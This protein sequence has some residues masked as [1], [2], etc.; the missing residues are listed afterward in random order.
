MGQSDMGVKPRYQSNY[1][2]QDRQ[3]WVRKAIADK[4]KG[5]LQTL[6][7]TEEGRWFIARLLKNEGLHS[8]GFTG[9]SGTFYNEGRRSVAVDIYTNIKT[10]LGVDAI[11]QLHKAQEDLMEFEERALEMAKANEEEH[12]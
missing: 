1:D 7:E 3:R 8:S 12:G 11:R 4:D 9:N 10:L 5:A 6:L 2:G